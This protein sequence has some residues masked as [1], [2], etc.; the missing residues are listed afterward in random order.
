MI[1]LFFNCRVTPINITKQT[2][3]KKKHVPKMWHMG[4]GS[5][6]SS[7][8][9]ATFDQDREGQFTKAKVKVKKLTTK[10]ALTAHI[11]SET[12]SMNIL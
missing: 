8:Q 1:V 5:S 9:R 7:K 10:A 3:K 12:T 2:I 11:L 4:E 6:Y